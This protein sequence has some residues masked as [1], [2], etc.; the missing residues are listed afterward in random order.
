MAWLTLTHT[1]RWH[2]HRHS[3]GSG[4]VYQGRFKSRPACHGFHSMVRSVEITAAHAVQ[5]SH[6][7]TIQRVCPF[8]QYRYEYSSLISGSGEAQKTVLVR[9]GRS[10]EGGR[11]VS[12]RVQLEAELKA[13]AALGKSETQTRYSNE[14]RDSSGVLCPNCQR[15]SPRCVERWF[16][17][18]ETAALGTAQVGCRDKCRVAE[19]RSESGDGGCG[20]PDAAVRQQRVSGRRR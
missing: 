8:C 9:A 4:H 12:R 18:S 14:A 20:Q 1:H 2:A 10:G 13:R 3:A 17:Q 5:L 19:G 16:P 6:A 11:E 7:D 15:F